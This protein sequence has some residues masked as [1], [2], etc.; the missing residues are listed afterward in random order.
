ML[1]KMSLK[2]KIL[3]I[4]LILLIPLMLIIQIYAMPRVQ[5]RMLEDRK[6]K[7]KATVEIVM[8]LIVSHKKR[9]AAGEMTLDEAQSR[10][11]DIVSNLRYEEKEYFWIND[12]KP[13]MVLHAVKPELNGKFLGEMKDPNGV[14]LFNEMVKIVKDRKAG[15]VAYDWPKPGE[16]KP[17][18]K[19][20]YVQGDPDWG[21]IV[22]T[23]VYVDDLNKAIMD[24][25][26][27][28][29][30]GI[31]L[32]A[33]FAG[34][35]AVYTTLNI[36]KNLMNV[37]S[38]LSV[39][40]VKVAE[41]VDHLRSAGET[42]SNSSTETAASLEETVASL[43]ELTSMVRVNTESS[44]AAAELSQK[45][46]KTALEGEVEVKELMSSMKEIE[47]ASKKI[48]EII[49]VIDD[50]AFQ[51]NLLAL[52]ASVEAARAGDQGKGFA[53]VADAVRTL[54]Q[55]SA[56]AAKD[57]SGLIKESVDKISHGAEIAN[58]T[59]SVFGAIV[60]SVAQVADL[61]SEIAV[62]SAEQTTG[63]QQISKAM[64]QLDQA[65]QGNAASAEEISATTNEIN[66]LA[67]LTKQM[68]LD[69]NSVIKGN[70]KAS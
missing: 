64:N 16:E 19:Y 69:L 15:Y 8:S 41:A 55:R 42:L 59:G 54:A 25:K 51:T 56:T 68:T 9:V 37:S 58:R 20:S 48:E 61:N 18:P 1:K 43:E 11:K 66:T 5:S 10:V 39:S 33:L 17:Q 52:N 50:I 27:S 53:V 60:K 21:W 24:F 44:K 57:I 14:F 29:W 36:S 23:G 4:V 38:E 49:G 67:A 28:L 26:I 65:A 70:Q 7:I 45:S 63:I 3:A 40:G 6:A 13:S 34:L 47:A 32:V 12:M 62:A 2:A 22:G 35:F 30:F 46:R 31:G